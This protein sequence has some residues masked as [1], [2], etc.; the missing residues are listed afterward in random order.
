MIHDGVQF[1]RLGGEMSVGYVSCLVSGSPGQIA[2]ARDNIEKSDPQPSP[3]TCLHCPARVG[4]GAGVSTHSLNRQTE[5]RHRS[6]FPAHSL[7]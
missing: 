6:Q 1:L 4:A 3:P 2:G 5:L 7:T